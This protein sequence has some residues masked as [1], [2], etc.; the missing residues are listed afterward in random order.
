MADFFLWRFPLSVGHS[1][2]RPLNIKVSWFYLWSHYNHTE[3]LR[4]TFLC[5]LVTSLFFQSIDTLKL[6]LLFSDNLCMSGFLNKSRFFIEI[7]SVL[8]DLRQGVDQGL[9]EQANVQ[10]HL[11]Q[12]EPWSGV[13]RGY[14]HHLQDERCQ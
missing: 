1:K 13:C 3:Y 11:Q 12:P 14:C 7:L 10:I 9:C 6:K 4:Y 5:P 8:D 2:K